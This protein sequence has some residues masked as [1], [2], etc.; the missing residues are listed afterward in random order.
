M[1][2]LFSYELLRRVRGFNTNMGTVTSHP[3]SANCLPSHLTHAPGAPSLALGNI[4]LTKA[5]P[6]DL[7]AAFSWL[8]GC[9]PVLTKVTAQRMGEHQAS[10]SLG[11]PGVTLRAVTTPENLLILTPGHIVPREP[12][13]V[14]TCFTNLFLFSSVIQTAGMEKGN[15]A[16][17]CVH[18]CFL[19]WGVKTP[20]ALTSLPWWTALPTVSQNKPLTP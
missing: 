1:S 3:W 16:A 7:V 20:A 9:W 19:R 12:L 13:S 6:W 11:P 2:L 15:W 14:L 8:C 18:L 10:H 5:L 4:I 17:A